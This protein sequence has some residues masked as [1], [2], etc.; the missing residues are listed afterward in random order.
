MTI[1]LALAGLALATI[2]AVS[3]PQARDATVVPM[4]KALERSQAASPLIEVRTQRRSRN[5]G[6]RPTAPETSAVP[7]GKESNG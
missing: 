1:R 7:T 4:G 5:V 3:M 2:G 6:T